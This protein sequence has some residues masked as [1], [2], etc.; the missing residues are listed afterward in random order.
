MSIKE[1]IVVEGCDAGTSAD[2]WVD[3][4]EESKIGTFV[5]GEDSCD[6]NPNSNQGIGLKTQ[7]LEGTKKDNQGRRCANVRLNCLATD[8]CP[9]HKQT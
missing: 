7:R 8:T 6:D 9:F 5:L 3:L 1:R 2:V 4:S